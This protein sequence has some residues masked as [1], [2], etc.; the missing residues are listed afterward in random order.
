MKSEIDYFLD[1][2]SGLLQFFNENELD[3][4][5]QIEV[6]YDYAPFGGQLGQT[7]VGTRAEL[8]LVPG[9][10]Q[11]G[12]TFLYTFAPKTTVVPDVRST[13][14]SLMVLEVDGRMTDV[15]VPFSTLKF[16]LSGEAAQ[17]RENPNLYGKALVDSMEGVAQ[18]DAIVLDSDLWVLG[19]NPDGY[20]KPT[21]PSSV[22]LSE[23]DMNLIDVVSPQSGV[24]D[25]EKL[26]VMA[27]SYTHL[28]IV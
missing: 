24:K 19:S 6:T 27:V 22:A 28:I 10:L 1:T 16:S 9:R 20:G 17:S 7:L 2:V 3:D 13:P 25:N 11:F 5:S 14:S 23:L 12:S 26:K 8:A 15:S 4:N 18:E 21:D